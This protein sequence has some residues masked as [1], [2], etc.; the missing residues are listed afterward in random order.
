M[1]GHFFSTSS[2]YP[3]SWP[4]NN[5]F[6]TLKLA[7]LNG[8]FLTSG[9]MFT[10]MAFDRKILH[11]VWRQVPFSHHV[12]CTVVPWGSSSLSVTPLVLVNN[13]HHWLVIRWCLSMF[14]SKTF[15]HGSTCTPSE[16][17]TRF[18]DTGS[19]FIHPGYN[20]F[21]NI[22]T[23]N[24]HHFQT[25]DHPNQRMMSLNHQSAT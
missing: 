23:S 6:I 17:W 5:P 2:H 24:V 21:K 19:S 20:I 7:C 14:N 8:K 10:S 25:N 22:K 1:T 18:E 12:N 3:R 4:R 9:D 11:G 15:S 16:D 13:L